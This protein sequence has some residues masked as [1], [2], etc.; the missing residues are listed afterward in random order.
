MSN[1][2]TQKRPGIEGA[3]FNYTGEIGMDNFD[4]LN[5][6]PSLFYFHFVTSM[7]NKK[8]WRTYASSWTFHPPL[9]RDGALLAW[10]PLLSFRVCTLWMTPCGKLP[11][12]RKKFFLGK[13][14]LIKKRKNLCLWKI[15]LII[16]KSLL[17]E[18][19]L[20]HEKIYGCGKLPWSWKRLCLWKIFLIKFS[21]N[22]SAEEHSGLWQASMT[23]GF[24]TIVN[25]F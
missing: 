20:D 3:L 15:S 5:S 6:W 18:N 9:R 4:C 14:S 10:S 1:L 2:N 25:S 7:Q 17:A 22:G 12:S 11:L 21:E 19:P 16:E 8:L 13:T 23:K 24:A